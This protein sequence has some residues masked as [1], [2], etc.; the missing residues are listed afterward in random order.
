MRRRRIGP[1]AR[2]RSVTCASSAFEG[3]E[4]RW[5]SAALASNTSVSVAIANLMVEK[6]REC[7]DKSHPF[8]C[9]FDIVRSRP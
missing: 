3:G 1:T 7:G 5:A 8:E 6:I 9:V 4:V 2:P